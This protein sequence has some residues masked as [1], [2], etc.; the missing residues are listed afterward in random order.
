MPASVQSAKFPVW[1]GCA[2]PLIDPCKEPERVRRWPVSNGVRGHGKAP[3][4]AKLRSLVDAIV[5]VVRDLR[6]YQGGR[7]VNPDRLV[8]GLSIGNG[9]AVTIVWNGTAGISG[10]ALC[11]GTVLEDASFAQPAVWVATRSLDDVVHQRTRL[12]NFAVEEKLL[13]ESTRRDAAWNGWVGKV[14]TYGGNDCVGKGSKE[15]TRRGG[16]TYGRLQIALTREW[17]QVPA[18]WSGRRNEQCHHR[19]RPV[20]RS[21]PTDNLADKCGHR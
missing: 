18:V 6:C 12:C 20:G 16:H 15:L 10:F 17:G 9:D 11:D 4:V 2:T 8:W 1:P 13:R 3:L 21:L 19:G 14:S 7:D 5:A